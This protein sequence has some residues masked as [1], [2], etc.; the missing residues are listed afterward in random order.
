MAIFG[1]KIK[2]F[3]VREKRYWL[4]YRMKGTYTMQITQWNIGVYDRYGDSIFG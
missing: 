3:V 1:I 2:T 4:I